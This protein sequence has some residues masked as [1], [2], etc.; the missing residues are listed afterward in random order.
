MNCRM[1]IAALCLTA[2]C[3][4]CV[5]AQTWPAR[6]VKLVVGFWLRPG[7]TS[8]A[9]NVIEFTRE[10]LARMPSYIRLRI[11]RADSGFCVA[12]WL[13]FLELRE[14]KYIVVA[15]LLRPL[16]QILK[17]DLIWKPTEVPGTDSGEEVLRAI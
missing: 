17:K 16:Q 15:K 14:L 7:N 6:P 1:L 3:A 5:Q 12:E 13:D 11:V 4:P 9:N 2:L 10:L 8:C